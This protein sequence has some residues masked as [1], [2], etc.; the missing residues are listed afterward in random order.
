MKINKCSNCI[1]KNNKFCTI[2]D[3]SIKFI[4]KCNKY[5]SWSNTFYKILEMSN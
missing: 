1:Y 5:E 4:K 2:H 3:K